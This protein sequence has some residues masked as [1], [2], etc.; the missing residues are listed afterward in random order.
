MLLFLPTTLLFL[1]LSSLTEAGNQTKN[2]A[3]DPGQNKLQIGTYEF[4]SQCDSQTFCNSSNLCS[5]KGCRID[6]YSISWPLGG[7][8][9]P[10]RCDKGQFC[11]DEEDACQPLLRVD[12][13]CQLN[14]DG[15]LF[16]VPTQSGTL[17]I[18]CRFVRAPTQCQ[19]PR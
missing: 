12:S 3:C 6:E 16:D 10:D 4:W 17:M 19:R 18:C 13:D 14:R 8:D 15:S 9:E 5:P 11:P 1:S 7:K 2:G